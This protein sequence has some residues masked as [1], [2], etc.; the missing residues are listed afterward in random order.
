[1]YFGM[2]IR[3]EAWRKRKG[4]AGM[5]P[6]GDVSSPVWLKLVRPVQS[7]RV[8]ADLNCVCCRWGAEWDLIGQIKITFLTFSLRWVRLPLVI[9]HLGL[10][11]DVKTHLRTIK[12]TQHIRKQAKTPIQSCLTTGEQ[13]L[14]AV[15]AFVSSCRVRQGCWCGVAPYPLRPTRRWVLTGVGPASLRQPDRAN[16]APNAFQDGDRQGTPLDRNPSLMLASLQWCI[17][18]HDCIASKEEE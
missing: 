1:M 14:L 18:F 8:P 2:I 11:Q 17:T 5:F 6:S 15:L 13:K 3:N 9:L 4:Q 16:G 12:A 10:F 7:R